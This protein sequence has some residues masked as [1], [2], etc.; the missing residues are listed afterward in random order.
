[1]SVS[2]EASRAESPAEP[3]V[4][5]PG[6]LPRFK[7]KRGAPQNVLTSASAAASLL[8]YMCARHNEGSPVRSSDCQAWLAI[9][10]NAI[11]TNRLLVQQGATHQD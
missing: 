5:A 2:V 10:T 7:F 6:P 8:R 1:M 9:K 11:K 3:E 4:R